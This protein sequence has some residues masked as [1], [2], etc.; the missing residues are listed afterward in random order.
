MLFRSHYLNS[1]IFANEDNLASA[2]TEL[3]KSIEIDDSYLPS[4][5]AFAS[6]LIGQNKTDEAI[7]QYQKVVAKKPDSSVYTLIGMLYDA[8]QSFDNSETN[9]RKALELNPDNAIA[10]NNLAW[11]SAANDKG[12]LDEALTLM[13]SLTQKN[14]TTAGYYD[15]LGWI[16]FKKGLFSPAVESLKKATAIDAADAAKNG[17]NPNPA[18]RLRLGTA[19][20]SAGDKSSAK[21][22]VEFALRGEKDL[23]KE[24][25]VTAKNLLSSL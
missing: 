5:S 14:P 12:N 18:Y 23:S 15:T 4:Y 7:E 2:E 6:I 19:L 9:Y 17:R 20:A 21:K 8:K 3:K 24:D 25:A 10:I 22:E 1:D 16:Y 13:Q 11:N